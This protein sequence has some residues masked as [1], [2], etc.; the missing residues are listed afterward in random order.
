MH[1]LS[2]STQQSTLANTSS[3]R[4]LPGTLSSAP[5]VT[6]TGQHWN[7]YATGVKLPSAAGYSW[8]SQTFSGHHPA[9]DYMTGCNVTGGVSQLATPA[10]SDI[11][12]LSRLLTAEPRDDSQL[13]AVTETGGD[14]DKDEY[15]DNGDESSVLSMSVNRFVRYLLRTCF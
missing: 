4:P 14:D 13:M 5:I 3:S 9:Y 7:G 15:D 1:S 10:T 11:E 2:I 12:P 8:M 6:T